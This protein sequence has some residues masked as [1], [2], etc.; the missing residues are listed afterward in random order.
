MSSKPHRDTWERHRELFERARVMKTGERKSFLRRETDEDGHL[1]EQIL[2][3][4]KDERGQTRSLAVHASL[5]TSPTGEKARLMLG[6]VIGSYRLV[7]ILGQ[8][9]TGTVFLADRADQQ[10]AGQV[11]VKLIDASMLQG[12]FG[13]R[14]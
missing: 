5:L 12:S 6:R 11:A 2:S 1:V 8:G 10:Y 4:L 13:A 3:Q 14:F 7:S 9:G